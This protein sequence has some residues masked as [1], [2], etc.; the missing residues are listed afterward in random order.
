MTMRTIIFGGTSGIGYATAQLLARDG[1]Q[2][3][4]VSNDR[5]ALDLL[6][7]NIL[8]VYADVTNFEDLSIAVSQAA[9][10]FGGLDSMVYSAGIQRYGTVVET[11]EFDWDLV[12]SINLKGAYSASKASIPHFNGRDGAIVIVS[13]VQA[14]ACQSGV[15]A[16]AASKG[17]LNALTR[18]MA[19]DHAKDGI[20][21]NSVCPGSVDTPMLRHAA[22]LFGKGRSQ[23]AILEEWGA[24]HALGRV[25]TADEVAEVIKFLISDRAS[26]VSGAEIRVDGGL[27]AA[28]AVKTRA[29]D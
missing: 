26:F 15:A 22:G 16:Y 1:G 27:T 28:L 18:A 12:M 8:P 20:R 19:L 7:R 4:A 11:S 3:A 25:A 10:T 24:S 6:P 21:V 29:T 13:S 23:E 9:A 2:V 17:G 14:I 5:P